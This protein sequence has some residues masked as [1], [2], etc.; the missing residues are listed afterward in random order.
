MNRTISSPALHFVLIGGALFATQGLWSPA[1]LESAASDP[2]Q[3]EIVIGPA[4]LDE[5]RDSYRRIAARDPGLDAEQA[6]IRDFVD[7]EILYREALRRGLDKD[8]RSVK[9]R[10]VQKMR[11]L[12]GR[13][14]EDPEVLYREAVS[15][16][17]DRE[18]IVIRRLLIEKMRLLIKLGVREAPS[19]EELERF[20]SEHAED[21]RQ[22]ARVSLHHA[23]LSSDRR[24][25]T[26][27]ADAVELLR[28]L[29]GKQVAAA[30]AVAMGDAFPLGHHL[31]SN[32]EQN[33]AKLFGPQFAA[34]AIDLE[35]GAWHGP[36]R[37]AYG[38]HLIWIDRREPSRLPGLEPVRNQIEQRYL[39]ELRDA[40]LERAMEELRK[41][42][43][44]VIE[45]G[46]PAWQ[47]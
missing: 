38:T 1:Q 5:L 25:D 15:L 7:R 33:L 43:A 41:R 19:E 10:L 47:G 14:D 13:D 9:F 12:E 35:P 37:S 16:G 40:E 42:Y 17:L 23:F 18:D 24:R 45:D 20:Y 39:A 4:K 27:E 32:S 29:R 44:V 34:A 11:F 8:D 21:Y 31:R 46:D 30:D 6:L 22:P 36:I 2:A 3:F 28:E 26:L